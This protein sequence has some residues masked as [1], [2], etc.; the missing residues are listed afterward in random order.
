VSQNWKKND[1]FYGFSLIFLAKIKSSIEIKQLLRCEKI[2]NNWLQ[3]Q[4]SC[5]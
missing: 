4:A 3:G 5:P 2:G 1:F